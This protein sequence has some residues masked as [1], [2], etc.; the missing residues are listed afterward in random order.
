MNKRAWA[1]LR[2]RGQMWIV[3]RK[4]VFPAP[5]RVFGAGLRPV[6]FCAIARPE[7]FAAMLQ[8]AG[9]G[10]V[11]TV[12]FPDHHRYTAADMERVIEVAKGLK[13]I[14]VRDDGEGCGEADGGDAA[15]IGR[16]GTADGGRA[17]GR[18]CG[19]RSG[20]ARTGSEADRMHGGEGRMKILIVRVGAMGDVLHALPAV[21]ALRRSRGRSGRLIG[22]WTP[23][24]A[25]L[26][27]DGEGQG[28]GGGSRASC[29]DEEVVEGSGVA[30]D[31]ALGLRAAA[32]VAE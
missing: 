31:A 6:A 13:R 3:R 9:C 17:G 15:A 21:A 12:A 8:N 10:V 27:V 18:V 16:A 14:G 30:C 19:S 25:P 1:M 24:W 5:L 4:L 11:E 26:L 28:A 20:V 29:G 32:R 2:E 22:W 23:R 7:D